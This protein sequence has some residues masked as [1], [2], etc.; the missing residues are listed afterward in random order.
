MKLSIVIPVY[1]EKGTILEI[2]RRV[3]E[4]PLEKEVILV[5]DFSADGTREVLQG[6]QASD[7]VP[8]SYSG[9]DYTEG[10]KIAWK[11]GVAA[12][13]FILKYRFLD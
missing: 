5:D 9:R 7:E 2:L 3:R 13:Y 1:N 10:K 11:D 12:I 4:F 6:I 8:I